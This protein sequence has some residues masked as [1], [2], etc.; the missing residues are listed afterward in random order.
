MSIPKIN[1]QQKNATISQWNSI[2]F[3]EL[4]DFLS[5][6]P[7]SRKQLN[8]SSGKYKNIH[9]G[10]ILTKFPY[11]IDA[12][13]KL[14][15]FINECIDVSKFEKLKCGDVIIADTAEDFTVGRAVELTGTAGIDVFSGLHTMPCRPKVS[16]A[17][18][19]LGY[20]INSPAFHDQL[21]KLVTGTKVS[22]ISKSEIVKTWI[23]F[24][25]I[26]EQQKIAAFFTSLDEKIHNIERKI[27]ALEIAKASLMN[28]LFKQKIRFKNNNGQFYCDWSIG[29]LKDIV[30]IN[31]KTKLLPSSFIYIDL[32]SVVAG[33]IIN[34]NVINQSDAP[35]RAQRLLKPNDILFQMVRPYQKNNFFY[36]SEF[37]LSAVASTGFAQLRTK[38]NCP[39]FIFYAT[40]TDTF[41]KDVNDRCT[42]GTYPAINSTDLSNITLSIPCKEEQTKIANLLLEIDRKIHN[43]KKIARCMRTIKNSFMQEMFV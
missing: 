23:S 13:S 26:E 42:G 40:Q 34:I 24:P 19:F 14:L 3:K 35:S 1:F 18:G 21:R 28:N 31:P 33:E 25:K 7:I 41:I 2:Q 5:S 4:F 37:D 9:Y 20:Y 36:S 17:S 32:G 8:Y 15:P 27:I 6:K 29:Q 16:F 22:S 12:N 10:D 30:E 39:A 43:Q 38:N 11:L